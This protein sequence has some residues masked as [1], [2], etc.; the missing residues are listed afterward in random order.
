M[1]GRSKFDGNLREAILSTVLTRRWADGSTQD[2]SNRG[3]SILPLE[4]NFQILLT[5]ADIKTLRTGVLALLSLLRNF[6]F[7]KHFA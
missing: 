3:R 7:E 4:N 6:L 1:E 5:S 2:V